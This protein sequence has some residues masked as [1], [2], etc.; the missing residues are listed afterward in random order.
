[1]RHLCQVGP[2]LSLGVGSTGH[3]PQ[4]TTVIL[5]RAWQREDSFTPEDAW[6]NHVNGKVKKGELALAIGTPMEVIYQWT[7]VL[8]S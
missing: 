2:T 8:L 1:M 4:L 3:T 7:A 5:C 6:R